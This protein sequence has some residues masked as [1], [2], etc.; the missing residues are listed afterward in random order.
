MAV[1]FNFI[2]CVSLVSTVNTAINSQSEL[3]KT[4]LTRRWWVSD[5]F[6]FVFFRFLRIESNFF[7]VF[8]GIFIN[9][10]KYGLKPTYQIYHK[11]TRGHICH[12]H[13]HTHPQIYWM[14]QNDNAKETNPTTANICERTNWLNFLSFFFERDLNEEHIRIEHFCKSFFHKSL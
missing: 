1:S 2:C 12:M 3:L 13:T 7:T 8:H 4:M 5:W 9:N 6:Q 14:L 10:F 11:Y